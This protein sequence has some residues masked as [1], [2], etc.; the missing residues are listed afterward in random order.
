M[1]YDEALDDRIAPI[2]LPWGAV[3]KKMFGG[4]CYLLNGNMLAGVYRD[5]LILR[6]GEA[7]GDAALGETFVRPFDITGRPMR[8]W[9]MVDPGGFDGE[10]LDRWLDRARVF[11]E[12]LP[13]K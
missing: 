12:S 1:A 6:L 5:S 10:A 8:G 11:V 9:V 7:S 13:A 2:A 3:R 4:T